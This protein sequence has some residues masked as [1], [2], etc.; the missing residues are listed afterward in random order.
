MSHV[1]R[2]RSDGDVILS[3]VAQM[4]SYLI[5]H[6]MMSR[7]SIETTDGNLPGVALAPLMVDPAYQ[8]TG[9]GSS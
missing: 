4:G 1:R 3:L 5:G 2:L 6:I 9:V 7:V 8:N